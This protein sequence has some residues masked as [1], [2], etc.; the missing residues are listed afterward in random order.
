MSASWLL[1]MWLALLAQGWYCWYRRR[2]RRPPAAAPVDCRSWGQTKQNLY[3]FLGFYYTH[4]ATFGQ[5][6]GL[7]IFVDEFS[8]AFLAYL[9][10]HM[11][12]R[13][14]GK[15]MGKICHAVLR[16]LFYLKIT[17]D[18]AYSNEE[19]TRFQEQVGT[20]WLLPC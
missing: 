4:W 1:L 3:G 10:F 13:T 20:L 15:V 16:V 2:R 9:S 14:D 8:T 17:A 19:I 11:A 6:L 12:R 5:E 7:S 18:P